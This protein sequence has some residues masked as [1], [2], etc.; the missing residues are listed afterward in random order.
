MRF[1]APASEQ[2]AVP[3]HKPTFLS[4]RS[5]SQQLRTTWLGHAC[6]YTEFPSGL[7]V[8]FDP[9][10][11]HRCSPF[12]FAGPGRYTR[13]ACAIADLPFLDAVVISHSHYD[14]LSL[15]TVRD[16]Q[17]S[18]PDAHFFV[19]LG[20]ARWFQSVGIM[21]VTELDW[22]EETEVTVQLDKENETGSPITATISS[23]PSQHASSRYS[24]D[25]DQ[26]LWCSWAITSPSPSPSSSS[27]SAQSKSL[28][29]AGDTGYRSVPQLPAGEDD[30]SDKYADR[31]PVNPDFKKI[32]DIRGPFDLGLIPIGAYQPRFLMSSVHADPNDAVE[33]FRATKC[34]RALGI[35]W[36]TWA[37]TTEPIMEPPVKLR[38]ALRKRG[39]EET[40][41][42]D[43]CDIGES[44]SF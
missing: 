5:A 3:V 10:F 43:V 2:D 20:L 8:L 36:S 16:I 14:H 4:T 33:I 26:T 11:E 22:W 7:R 30:W 17:K 38:E 28:Y 18:F 41:V 34:R 40:G 39:L 37:L 21:N 23:L 19:G 24:L 29:F 32:G 27:S 42:F 6:H 35:H 25:A 44:R 31:F 12:N 1:P 15:P 9:V 13:P